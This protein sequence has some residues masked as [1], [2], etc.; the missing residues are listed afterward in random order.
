MTEKAGPS[1]A[2]SGLTR[3]KCLVPTF[4]LLVILTVTNLC[5]DGLTVL[6]SSGKKAFMGG[7]VKKPT[8]PARLQ[9]SVLQ[10]LS[11]LELKQESVQKGQQVGAMESKITLHW[12]AW[13]PNFLLPKFVTD[14]RRNLL[15]T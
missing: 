1:F 8:L 10:A 3:K 2:T 14:R 7:R 13:K 11:T 12:R 5:G 4:L 15:D 9:Q 6:N